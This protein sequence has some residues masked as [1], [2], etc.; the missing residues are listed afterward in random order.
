AVRAFLYHHGERPTNA[1]GRPGLPILVLR[2][3]GNCHN[4]SEYESRGDRLPT[5]PRGFRV[6]TDKCERLQDSATECARTAPPRGQVVLPLTCAAA[7]Q[8][9]NPESR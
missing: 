3:R 8:S 1:H 7:G 6:S 9:G 4:G 5:N 2:S